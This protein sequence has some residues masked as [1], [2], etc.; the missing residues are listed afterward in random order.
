MIYQDYLDS[1]ELK[2]Y[3]SAMNRRAREYQCQ[4]S[5]T[6]DLLRDRIFESGGRCEWCATDLVNHEFEL[7][8]LVSLSR[9][10]SN[11][12]DN[13]VVSC[14]SCNRR[15]SGKHV[16]RFAAEI[17]RETGIL[18]PYVRQI[19]EAHEILLTTQ[20]HL[21]DDESTPLEKPELQDDEDTSSLPPYIW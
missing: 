9:K 17:Y 16:A 5:L 8:H 1:Q 4:G 10:G 12:P 2:R 19:L 15:K 11:T 18:T 13:I 3:A 7:D 21:F 14:P 20:K 6:A